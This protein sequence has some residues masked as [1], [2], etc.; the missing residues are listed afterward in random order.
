MT[1][2]RFVISYTDRD[3]RKEYASHIADTQATTEYHRGGDLHGILRPEQEHR[4][5]RNEQMLCSR[6]SWFADEELSLEDAA[7]KIGFNKTE[8]TGDAPDAICSYCW[9]NVRDEI[10]RTTNAETSDTNYDT[11]G[12]RLRWKQKGRARD[13][14]YDIIVH[15][16]TTL[17]EVD[18]L[19][20]RLF[21]TIYGDHLRMYGFENEYMD[22]TLEAIPD[23][24]YEYVGNSTRTSQRASDLTIADIADQ[25]TLREGDKL[26]MVCDFG[27]PSR[28]YCI[29]KET[30]AGD[31][32]TSQ[33][34]EMPLLAETDTAGV[35]KQRRPNSGITTAESTTP[36]NSNDDSRG[37]SGSDAGGDA[38]ATT[39]DESLDIRDE[40]E[41][42]FEEIT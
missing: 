11:A 27:T 39:D 14:W 15:P 19:I 22:S 17:D 3:R 13:E 1:T 16:H 41:R 29:V 28:Y 31:A 18:T 25:A 9:N 24:Q 34:K 7:G 40:L 32:V 37:D 30:L 5:K 12:F 26:S 21:T 10:E 33:L 36:N 8:F 6:G 42:D 38:S 4:N 35:V 23:H 20:A 2:P